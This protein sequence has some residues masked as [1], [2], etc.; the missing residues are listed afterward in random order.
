[1]CFM[2][3][4]KDTGQIQDMTEPMGVAVVVKLQ[5]APP[6]GYNHEGQCVEV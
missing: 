2:I 3:Q 4:S 6:R 5:C 1:M